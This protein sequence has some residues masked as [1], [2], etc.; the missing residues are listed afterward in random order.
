MATLQP[1][2]LTF[3]MFFTETAKKLGCIVQCFDE[4]HAQNHSKYRYFF[5]FHIPM[6]NA[7]ECKTIR[8]YSVSMQHLLQKKCDSGNFFCYV[9]DVGTR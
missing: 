8:D 6:L 1:T 5:D 3:T 2:M 7:K 4:L 9:S